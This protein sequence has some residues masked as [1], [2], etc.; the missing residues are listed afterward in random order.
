VRAREVNAIKRFQRRCRLI[1]ETLFGNY[2]VSLNEL[3][4]ILRVRNASRIL[5]KSREEQYIVGPEARKMAYL[6]F[7]EHVYFVDCDDP[8]LLYQKYREDEN[9]IFHALM[10]GFANLWVISKEKI[11]IEGALPLNNKVMLIPTENGE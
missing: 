6:N 7:P 2:R 1:Y 4:G 9:I 5:K 10:Y 8:N 3:R 11:D